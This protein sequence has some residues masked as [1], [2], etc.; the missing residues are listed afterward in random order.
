MYIYTMTFEDITFNITSQIPELTEAVNYV[1]SDGKKLRANIIYHLGNKTNV[2]IHFAKV[3]EYIHNASLILDDL[4]CMDNSDTRRGKPSLHKFKSEYIAQ[5]TA[6]TLM[7]RA[8]FELYEGMQILEQQLTIKDFKILREY[9]MRKYF[10]VISDN[11]LSGGQYHDL[12][13]K[14]YITTLPRRQQQE[15][16]IRIMKLK[17]GILFELAFIMG[18][19]SN[20]NT[21]TNTNTLLQYGQIGLSLGMCYQIIDDLRDQDESSLSNLC[22]YFDKNEI[23]DMFISFLQIAYKNVQEL[24]VTVTYILDFYR[25]LNDEFKKYITL[26]ES[27]RKSHHDLPCILLAK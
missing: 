16:I 22:K 14:N 8:Q 23:I 5:L 17:T 19:I 11:G 25:Y 15:L 7:S 27:N 6:M 20:T 18:C 24:G 9:L 3:V 13:V 10:E 12:T 4:P 26:L 21:N 2:S 1:L